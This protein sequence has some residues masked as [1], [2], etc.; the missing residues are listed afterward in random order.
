MHRMNGSPKMGTRVQCPGSPKM[1]RERSRTPPNPMKGQPMSSPKLGRSTK[2]H[3]L[4]NIHANHELSIAEPPP[5]LQH[6]SSGPIHVS[7]HIHAPRPHKAPMVMDPSETMPHPLDIKLMSGG[8]PKAGDV[9]H[10]GATRIHS[11]GYG[12]GSD[13]SRSGTPPHCFDNPMEDKEEMRLRELE[14]ARARAAQMEKT[15]RWWS[16]CTANWREKWG[17]VR[18]ERN[19]AREEVRQLRLKLEATMKEAISLKREKHGLLVDNE[20]LR[21][22]IKQSSGGDVEASPLDN[23]NHA[24]DL[25]ERDVGVIQLPQDLAPPQ[26]VDFVSQLMESQDLPSQEVTLCDTMS[27][28]DLPICRPMEIQTSPGWGPDETS[29]TIMG[30]GSFI[31][32]G[33]LHDLN[34]DSRRGSQGSSSHGSRDSPSRRGKTKEMPSPSEEKAE[35]RAFMLQMKLD[36]ASKTIQVERQEKDTLHQAINKLEQEVSSL[37]IRT[38]DLQEAKDTAIR[39][40]QLLKTSHQQEIGRIINDL[41]DEASSRNH[42]DKRLGALRK[43]LERLQAE[44]AAEWGK[45]ERLETEKLNL[46][47]ENKKQRSEIE[48]LR[49]TISIRSKQT[50]MEMENTIKNTQEDLKAKSAELTELKHSHN[51]M[52]KLLADKLAELDHTTTRCQ[53]HEEDVKKLRIRVDEL[54]RDLARREDEVDER[55]NFVK[56]IQ[57]NLDET[58]QQNENLTLQ[59]DHLQNRLRTQT[60]NLTIAK[61]RMSTLKRNDNKSDT[62]SC[63][64]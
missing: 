59:I 7:S 3:S 24:S 58:L 15:M 14:E 8:P 35:Q 20:Q 13:S 40:V 18:A 25:P 60:S 26:G 17:K 57:R 54:K 16:D 42:M 56:K 29:S 62:E 53:Q 30:N 61:K 21:L 4:G 50:T 45:R 19:K 12:T 6:A 41:E 38:S 33:G 28:T 44:N 2:A 46:E 63:S 32:G 23:V 9:T 37:K 52:K 5:P 1:G 55:I 43:E 64:D 34:L 49:E 39:E 22:K 48:D 47:R 11:L 31:L 10:V 36:E 27:Q 51:K